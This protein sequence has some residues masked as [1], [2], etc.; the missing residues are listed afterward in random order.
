MLLQYIP[1][2]NLNVA[3]D[4]YRITFAPELDNLKRSIKSVGVIQPINIRHTA[5]GTFQI[6]TGYKRVLVMQEI[7]R[8]SVPALIHEPGD[9]SPTQAFLWNLHD[10]AITRSLNL[11]EKS[12][13]LN[14]LQQFYSI[15]E[16][17]LAK[18][19]LPLLGIEPSYKILHQLCAL[20]QLIE[21]LKT[22]I[23][24]SQMALSSAARIADFSPTTQ[25]ALLAVLLHI[26]PSTS[27]LNEL[28]SLLRE[29]SARDGITVEDILSRYKLLQV[30]ANPEATSGEK[31]GALRQALR[32]IR[33]PQLTQ[34]QKELA[35]LIQNL[36]LPDSAKVVADPYFENNNMKLEY[37]FS[38]PKELDSLVKKIQDAFSKQKWQQIFEWYRN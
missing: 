6:V 18:Q 27:K 12:I 15:A 23:V 19:F 33:L 10:N 29:I 31:V 20:D 8:Q 13:A 5:E 17:D 4:S 2:K 11:V 32:G 14:K 1:L 21:P 22:H 9:L 38:N 7:E 35:N 30:V 3:D 34:R 16:D 36:E 28:L 26:R 25:Q 24:E 37:R